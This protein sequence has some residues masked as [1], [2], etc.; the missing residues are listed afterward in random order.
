MESPNYTQQVTYYQDPNTPNN[1][2]NNY[3][4]NNNN[5]PPPPSFPYAA[6][7]TCED[8]H[9]VPQAIPVTVS[10]HYATPVYAHVQASTTRTC[11]GCRRPFTPKPGVTDAQQQ[12]YRCEECSQLGIENF[13]VVQ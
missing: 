5:N 11:R 4:Y 12:F 2:S 6:P 13:C 3:N 1:S 7:N 10:A 9:N 8:N